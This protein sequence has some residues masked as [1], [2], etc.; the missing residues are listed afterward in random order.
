MKRLGETEYQLLNIRANTPKR[1][2]YKLISIWL[3]TE[4]KKAQRDIIGNEHYEG[5]D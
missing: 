5:A 2:D 3:D 1:P 4:M